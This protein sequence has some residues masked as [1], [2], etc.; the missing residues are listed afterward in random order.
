MR[1]RVDLAAGLVGR[2]QVIFLD[3]PTT[4]LDP[5]SRLAMWD[6][7]RELVT[8]GATV[9]LTTQYL[10]EADQLAD[11]ITVIDEGRVA[12]EGTAAQLK[13]AVG[14]ER[15]DLTF[16]DEPAARRAATLLKA[17]TR[18]RSIRVRTDGRPSQLRE[19]L[20]ELAGRGLE[21]LTIALS[22]P[23]LDEVFLALTRPG[24]DKETA[25]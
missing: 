5:L 13:A 15:A 2:P 21:P 16:E 25:A 9:L 18:G 22:K 12:A 4:G 1:R 20:D 11:R 24:D 3:E 8:E 14:K 6:L 23:S 17:T 7:V 19:L 10:E